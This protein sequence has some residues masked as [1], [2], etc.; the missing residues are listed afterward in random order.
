ME[1]MLSLKRSAVYRLTKDPTF[2]P[3]V[4]LGRSVRWVRSEVEEW[5]LA[6]RDGGQSVRPV[7]YLRAQDCEP[8]DGDDLGIVLIPAS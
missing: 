6:R 3:P 7:S 8:D 1:G 5:V 2:P 4:H